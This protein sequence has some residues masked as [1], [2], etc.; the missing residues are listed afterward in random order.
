[1]SKMLVLSR[2]AGESIL[3]KIT[4]PQSDTPT[5]DT[6]PHAARPIEITLKIL[7]S[8]A[9]FC[10]LGIAAPAYCQ[11][12]RSELHTPPAITEHPATPPP[13]EAADE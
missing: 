5:A 8:G 2:R 12:L 11:I 6:Q 3:L 7:T 9:N 4:P 10:R 1:M 13:A